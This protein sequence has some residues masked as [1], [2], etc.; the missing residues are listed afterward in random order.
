MI[1]KRCVQIDETF[2]HMDFESSIP[3]LSAF[4]KLR[5]Y[6]WTPAM[7]LIYFFHQLHSID[8]LKS[9]P[10]FYILGGGGSLT[11]EG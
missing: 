5:F 8:K 1:Q 9:G 6:Y 4:F 11:Q 2:I 3:V 10:L 7:W